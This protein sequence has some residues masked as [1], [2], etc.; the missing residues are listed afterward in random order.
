MQTFNK[1]VTE[2]ILDGTIKED[3]FCGVR[4]YR[5]RRPKSGEEVVGYTNF[6]DLLATKTI[7]EDAVFKD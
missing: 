2:G 3:S 1:Y 7:T 5:V 6:S 4:I